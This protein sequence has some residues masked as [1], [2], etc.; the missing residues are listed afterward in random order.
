MRL[1]RVEY[2]GTPRYGRL[3]DDKV[4]LLDGFPADLA[5]AAKTADFVPLAE[6]RLLVPAVPSKIIAI[7]RNYAAHVKEMGFDAA[8]DDAPS[9]FIKPLQTLVDPGGTVILP[10]RS[11]ESRPEHEAEL[12][13]VIGTAARGVDRGSADEYI[14]GF[15][16]AN[17]VSARELQKSDP[18]ITRGKGF[19][20]FCPLGPWIETDVS[21]SDER[22]VTCTVNGELRQQGNTRDLIYSIPYLIEWLSGW[23]TLEPGDV[24]L[25]GSPSGTGPLR[26]GDEVSITVEG[27]GELRHHVTGAS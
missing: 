25:T 3:A 26:D 17:D 16:C 4:A 2:A 11:V 9:V 19:D 21:A 18:Q 13:V 15:T 6:C 14:L 24:I 22:D 20:T 23:T 27:V 8:P 10:P 1:V 7:G 12:A 5:E